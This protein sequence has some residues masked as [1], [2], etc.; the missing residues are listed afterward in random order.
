MGTDYRLCCHD[1]KKVIDIGRLRVPTHC[2]TWEEFDSDPLNYLHAIE[3][4]SEP[5]DHRGR[6][7]IWSMVQM[8]NFMRDHTAHRVALLTDWEFINLGV[9]D[10]YEKDWG[11]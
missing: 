5:K 3:G 6:C 4:P 11:R 1:C 2:N 10:E 8:I 9:Y 7:N